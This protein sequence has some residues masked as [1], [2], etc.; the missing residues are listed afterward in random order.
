[1]SIGAARVE[2]L[3]V[4]PGAGGPAVR[5]VATRRVEGEWSHRAAGN[6]T[7]C[8]R[9]LWPARRVR[10]RAVAHVSVAHGG[11]ASNNDLGRDLYCLARVGRRRPG[12]RTSEPSSPWWGGCP[13][14][15]SAATPTCS[16]VR[17]LTPEFCC[18]AARATVEY[19]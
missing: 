11:Q 19:A 9:S 16:V 13:S 7:T 17:G 3:R 10:R 1:M 4:D 15:H 2:R 18:K 12:R 5:L 8:S 14:E 6:P